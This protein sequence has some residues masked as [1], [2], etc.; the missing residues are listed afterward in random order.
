MKRLF[1]SLAV[2]CL[3]TAIASTSAINTLQVTIGAGGNTQISTL[4]L[5]AK[6]VFI[7][8]NAAHDVRVGDSNTSTTKG[9]L[10]LTTT[11]GSLTA[12][13]FLDPRLINLKEWFVAGTQND[14]VDVIYIQ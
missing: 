2:V 9:A 12:G 10:L 11:H 5:F 1:Q 13:P 4:D 14:V 6:E 3:L 8:N 7:Q